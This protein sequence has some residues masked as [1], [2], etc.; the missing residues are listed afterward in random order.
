MFDD[1]VD[2]DKK[3]YVLLPFDG[4]LLVGGIAKLMTRFN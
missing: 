2:V 4:D 1:T 3:D